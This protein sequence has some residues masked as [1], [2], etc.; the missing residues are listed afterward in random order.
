MGFTTMTGSSLARRNGV[1]SYCDDRLRTL[2][3]RWSISSSCGNSSE[4]CE[5]LLRADTVLE[6]PVAF[7]P[8]QPEARAWAMVTLATAHPDLAAPAS[9]R[10][11]L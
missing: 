8:P 4:G 9:A 1:T 10:S 3:V 6:E 5:R 11:V 2:V 7:L